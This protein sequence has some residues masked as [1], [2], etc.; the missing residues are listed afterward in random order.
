MSTLT[1]LSTRFPLRPLKYIAP[2]RGEKVDNVPGDGEYLGLEQFESWT[3]GL[4]GVALAQAPEGNANVFQPGDVLFGKLRP[5]LAKGWVADRDG[6]STTESLVLR[7][8]DADPR[9][10]RYCLLT[11]EVISAVD[12]ST[13]GTKMP[14]ADWS[15]VGAVKLPLPPKADQTRI[16]N[17][18]DEKTAR[19]DALIG[20]KERLVERLEEYWSS[21][22]CS[23]LQS[24]A[25]LGLETTRAG[26]ALE[27]VK[28]V[29][30][31]IYTGRTPSGS[32]DDCFTEDGVP[33]VTPGDMDDIF[34]ASSDKKVSCAA[35]RDGEVVLYPP[36][37]TLLVCI[38]ATLGTVSNAKVSVS[39]N[40]QINILVPNSRKIDALF[41][42][43]SIAANRDQVR[44]S[45]GAATLPILNQERTG[46]LQIAVP[47]MEQQIVMRSQLLLLKE[48]MDQ[49]LSHIR[50]HISLL[51]EH[52]SSLISAAVTGQ[53]NLDSFRSGL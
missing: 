52:R 5:Y 33:W 1:P 20:E 48:N 10:V 8:L 14:R 49:L 37:S 21:R 11:R 22:L 51:R 16:A 32:R 31:S 13:Y 44:L 28:R 41:L 26:W 17:F 3:G 50:Q 40:Q 43:L 23:L 47:N 7:P 2:L 46:R 42:T 39:A 27:R 35:L 45:A 34:V 25:C 38:G 53:L 19:I 4:S 12:G 15:F 29:C 24:A 30:V 9:F 6:Y 36:G 18:L